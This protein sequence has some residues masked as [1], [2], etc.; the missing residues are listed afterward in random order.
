VGSQN[1]V[2]L[3]PDRN[4]AVVMLQFQKSHIAVGAFNKNTS[5]WLENLRVLRAKH[6]NIYQQRDLGRTRDCLSEICEA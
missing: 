6:S 2:R 5:V 3:I 1:F 4:V